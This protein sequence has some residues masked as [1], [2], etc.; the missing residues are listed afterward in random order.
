MMCLA[1]FAHIDVLRDDWV[2]CA[3]VNSTFVKGQTLFKVHQKETILY[4]PPFFQIKVI[5]QRETGCSR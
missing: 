2:L 3:G 4:F 5:L 1:V